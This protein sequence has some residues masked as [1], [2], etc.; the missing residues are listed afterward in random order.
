M[1]VL[2]DN[3]DFKIG[4]HGRLG[5]LNAYT[6]WGHEGKKPRKFSIYDRTAKQRTVKS[7]AKLAC[8]FFCKSL[9]Y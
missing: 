8:H 3:R 1:G 9:N 7:C 5:R 6:A 2:K 4:H